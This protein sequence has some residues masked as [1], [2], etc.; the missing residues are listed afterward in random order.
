SRPLQSDPIMCPLC[1]ELFTDPVT[2]AC[3]HNF[4]MDCLQNYWD[5]QAMIG[6]SPYCPLSGPNNIPCDFCSSRKLKPIKT[7]LQ[8]TPS[9]CETHTQLHYKDKAYRSHQLLEPI[10]DLKARLCLKHHKLQKQNCW[11]EGGFL[12]RTRLQEGR[13]DHEAV[14]LQG[15]RATKAV[16]KT[17]TL[18][19]GC[20]LGFLIA[21]CQHSCKAIHTAAPWRQD[22]PADRSR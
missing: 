3:G 5:H 17:V 9:L 6:E 11:A 21:I 15:E 20:S 22:P 16:S 19:T 14:P 12:G 7:C 10:S 8:C 2:T 1:L 4:C 18:V 13:R